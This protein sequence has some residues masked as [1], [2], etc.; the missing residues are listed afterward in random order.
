MRQNEFSMVGDSAY[1]IARYINNASHIFPQM[2]HLF[3]WAHA[4]SIQGARASPGHQ[5]AMATTTKV[6]QLPL[7]LVQVFPPQMI[8]TSLDILSATQKLRFWI[9]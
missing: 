4:P 2:T 7:E 9:G 8:S 6:V 5:G 3:L 1:G